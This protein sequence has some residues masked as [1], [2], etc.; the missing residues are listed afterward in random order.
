MIRAA[1]QKDATQVVPLVVNVLKDMELPLLT[2]IGE[3]N[4]TEILEEAYCLPDYRYSYENAL[5]YE[6]GNQID[7]IA[8][9]YPDAQEPTIDLPLERLMEKAGYT[10]NLKL[11]VDKETYPNEW[12]LDTLSVNPQAQGKGIGSKL[13]KALPTVAK[14]QGLPTLGLNVDVVNPNAQR[15]YSRMGFT[16]VGQVTLSGHLYEHMQK[17]I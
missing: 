9:G 13:L 17:A 11:F 15:L 7:G 1:K 14:E 2:E 4:L 10:K 16:K 8:F 12:Y 5:V 6:Q 3:K